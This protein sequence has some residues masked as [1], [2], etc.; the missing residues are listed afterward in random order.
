M[1]A[2]DRPRRRLRAVGGSIRWRVTLAAVVVVGLALAAGAAGLM[3]LRHRPE[4]DTGRA[5]A[6]LRANEV[7]AVLEAGQSPGTLAVDD[8]EE[9]LIQVLDTAGKVVASSPN[10]AGRPPVADVRPG[11]AKRIDETPIEDD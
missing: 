2:D 10:M 3:S 6:R 5:A 7:A 4:G 8:E 9:V 1:A 11:Q